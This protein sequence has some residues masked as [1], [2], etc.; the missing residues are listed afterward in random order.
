MHIKQV[1]F[2][3]DSIGVIHDDVSER[4][5]APPIPITMQV[6]LSSSFGPQPKKG[7]VS[8]AASMH[9]REAI[10]ELKSRRSK[11]DGTSVD[12]FTTESEKNS[13]DAASKMPVHKHPVSS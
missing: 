11:Y 1:D 5:H 3:R 13:T 10:K 6:N 2:S 4:S 9:L 8:T 7:I 12:H